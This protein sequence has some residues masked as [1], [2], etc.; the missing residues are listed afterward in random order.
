MRGIS[1]SGFNLHQWRTT[2]HFTPALDPAARELRLH[3]DALHWLGHDPAGRRMTPTDTIPG[4]WTC[5]IALP[6]QETA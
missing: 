1:G 2:R 3:A 5:T 6:H 4:P